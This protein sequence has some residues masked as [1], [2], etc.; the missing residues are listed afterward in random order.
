MVDVNPQYCDNAYAYVPDLGG[1]GLVVYSFKDDD[2]WRVKHHYFHFDP[3]AGQY[4]VGGVD[5][6][7]TDGVFGIALSKIDSDGYTLLLISITTL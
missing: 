6:Q 7:W 4:N 3:L 2:S 5:F 1:Y